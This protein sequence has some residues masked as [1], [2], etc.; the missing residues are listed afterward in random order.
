MRLLTRQGK[1]WIMGW[2]VHN[3]RDGKGLTA[4]PA[5]V[6]P[7]SNVVIRVGFTALVDLIEDGRRI[8]YVEHR[9]PPHFPI[10]IAWMRIISEFD[11]NRPVIV[12][13]VLHLHPNLIVGQRWQERKCSLG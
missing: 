9:Q 7:H 12:Q 2:P 10:R 11:V 3:K 8:H 13:T 1:A 4:L 6:G 5:V